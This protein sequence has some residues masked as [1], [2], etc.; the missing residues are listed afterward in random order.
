MLLKLSVRYRVPSLNRT[1]RQH[2]AAQY[3]EKQKAFAALAS[4]LRDTACDPLIQT[5]SP[6]AA[7]TFS[8]AFVTLNSYLEMKRGESSLKPSKSASANSRK[9]GQK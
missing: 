5:T 4:A 7:K 6:E 2:W 3:Q 9:R 8:T 1:K